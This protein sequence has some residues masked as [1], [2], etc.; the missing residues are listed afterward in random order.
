MIKKENFVAIEGLAKNWKEAIMLCG[1]A[2]SKKGL[3][4]NEFAQSCIEREYEYP[5]GLP[6][7]IPVAIPHA[8]SNNIKES[9]I[10]FLRLDEPVEFKRMDDDDETIQTRLLFNLAIKDSGKHIQFLQKLMAFLM[11]NQA[12]EN[13]LRLDINE[14]SDYL[15]EHLDM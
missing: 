14:I 9:C 11:N 1:E 2:L 5:T 4:D 8:T 7:E 15:K 6:S 10:C 12:I 3:V 13:C